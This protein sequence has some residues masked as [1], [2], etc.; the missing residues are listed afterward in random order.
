MIKISVPTVDGGL[1]EFNK[2]DSIIDRLSTL[3]RSGYVG[4]E[5]IHALITDDWGPPPVGI[6]ICGTLKD[7]TRVD[8]YIAYK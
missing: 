2:S 1:L 5:L 8:E 4:K 6:S 3:R 7:G